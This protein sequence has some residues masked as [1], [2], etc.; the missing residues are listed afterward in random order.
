MYKVL[1]VFILVKMIYLSFSSLAAEQAAKDSFQQN[2]LKDI[3]SHLHEH[4]ENFF[5]YDGEMHPRTPL[6]CLTTERKQGVLELSDEDAAIL[7][8]FIRDSTYLI[9]YLTTV[10]IKFSPKELDHLRTIFRLSTEFCIAWDY[11]LKDV[12]SYATENLGSLQM[13]TFYGEGEFTKWV[14]N[15]LSPFTIRMG[16]QILKA[17][18]DVLELNLFYMELLDTQAKLAIPISLALIKLRRAE[19]ATHH[20]KSICW[21]LELRKEPRPKLWNF[22]TLMSQL[23]QPNT[24]RLTRIKHFLNGKKSLHKN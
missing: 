13:G 5:H 3:Q 20:L 10:S 16:S 15:F 4:P 14:V 9:S 19:V 11:P 18:A 22:I 21:W 8:F 6:A 17:S 7:S 2:N 24:S 23:T 12:F 1:S